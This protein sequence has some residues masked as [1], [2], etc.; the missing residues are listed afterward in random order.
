MF[1][2]EQK[3]EASAMVV[4]VEPIEANGKHWIAV[5]I[6]GIAMKRHGPLPDAVT[7][8]IAAARVRRFGRA[9]TNSSGG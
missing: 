1:A 4:E 9:L 8:E 2:V 7:A 5:V 3:R 6:D